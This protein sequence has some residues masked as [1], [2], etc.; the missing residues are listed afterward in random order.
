MSIG[1][2]L[3]PGDIFFTR[4]TL[5]IGRAIN[6]V[7]RCWSL[8]SASTY[9]HTGIIIDSNGDTLESLWHIESAN[10]CERRVN[11]KIAIFR[12]KYVEPE[13]LYNAMI[14][15]LKHEGQFYPIHRLFFHFFR[16]SR[17][18]HWKRVVCSELSVKFLYPLTDDNHFIHWFGWMPDD[19]HDLLT[20]HRD[21]D[22][23]FEGILLLSSEEIFAEES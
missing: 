10:L 3:E 22:L 15:V 7:G 4:N 16:I 5:W 9:S 20:A 14:R 17:F 8:D 21:F 18:F 23:V 11:E 12:Y 19:L 6:F 13:L 1:F 2:K